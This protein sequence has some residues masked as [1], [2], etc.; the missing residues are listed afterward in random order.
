[1]CCIG[2]IDKE[3]RSSVVPKKG[4]ALQRKRE[5]KTKRNFSKKVKF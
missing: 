3:G 4:G 1:L 5:G 2:H